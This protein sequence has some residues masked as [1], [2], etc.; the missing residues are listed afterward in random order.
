MI[1][2]NGKLVLGIIAILAIFGIA[3]LSGMH[4][5]TGAAVLDSSDSDAQVQGGDPPLDYD[6][7]VIYHTQLLDDDP[8]L[9]YDFI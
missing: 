5:N 9:D 3:A 4:V 6:F 2:M 8:P 7:I 1:Q